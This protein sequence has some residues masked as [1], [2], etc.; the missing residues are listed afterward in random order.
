MCC[1]FSSVKIDTTMLDTFLELPRSVQTFLITSF[2][3]IT[4]IIA[5]VNKV[6]RKESMFLL[7]S[8]KKK[9]KEYFQVKSSCVQSSL[10]IIY[11][12]EATLQTPNNYMLLYNPCFNLML[13]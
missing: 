2:F 4:E 6:L 5:I 10:L 13:S 11:L 9:K 12:G 8:E 1:D 3:L 7:K